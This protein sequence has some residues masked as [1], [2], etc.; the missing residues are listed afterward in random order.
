MRKLIIALLA[1][2]L[3]PV[4]MAQTTAKPGQFNY[5]VQT[6]PGAVPSSVFT[7]VVTTCATGALPSSGCLPVGHDAYV[8]YVDLTGNSVSV[9]I[10]DNQATPVVWVVQT[11]TTG[12]TFTFNAIEDK[13][14]RWFPSGVYWKAS[15]TGATGYM[16]VK[17]N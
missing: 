10:Q 6:L 9:T 17:Y 7:A 3:P 1:T 11:L 12:T 5:V 16:V 4:V 15:G 2:L 13:S 14:C 8:C